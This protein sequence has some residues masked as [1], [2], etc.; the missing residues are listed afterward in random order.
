MV[1]SS[2]ELMRGVV[3][4]L[5]PDG[6]T[7]GT[8]FLVHQDGFIATCS[9]V[10]QSIKDQEGNPPRPEKVRVRFRATGT[11][12]EALVVHWSPFTL[13]DVAILKLMG[14]VPPGIEPLPLG[15]SAGVKGH[16]LE[17]FGFPE[18]EWIDGLS[19]GG[20]ILAPT[21]RCGFPLLQVRSTEITAGFSGAP[22]WDQLRRRV[23]GMITLF[24]A[25]DKFGRL[26]ESAFLVPADTLQNLCPDLRA[27]DLCPYQGL[28]AF[29]EERSEFFFG[30]REVIEKLVSHLGGGSRFLAVLGPSGSGKSSLIRAGLIPRLRQGA[31]W[32]SDRWEIQVSRPLE[33][34]F[35]ALADQG[36][37]AVSAG[38]QDV[39]FRRLTKLSSGESLLLV[40]DQFE[41]LLVAYPRDVCAAIARQLAE[42]LGSSSPLI[43]ILVMRNDF[44]SLFAEL[45]VVLVPW[46]EKN[47]VN[48][49][50]RLSRDQVREIIVE[51]AG[52]VGWELEQGL[53]EV[54]LEDVLKTGGDKASD[55]LSAPAT[56][57]PLLEFALTELWEHS[58][59]E[60]LLTHDAFQRIKK[61]GGGLSQRAAGIY[62]DLPAQQ[63]DLA[64]QIFLD[65]V[66]LGEESSL[67][68][69]KRLCLNDLCAAE[70]D[71][72]QVRALVRHLSDE[73]QRL[74]VASRDEQSGREHV[75]IIHEA[76][77]REWQD[78]KDWIQ[79][80][81]RFL[82][83]R[84]ELHKKL[85]PWIDTAP[86]EPL[87]RDPERLLL[88]RDLTEA[89]SWVVA[90]RSCLGPE[91]IAY[92]DASQ[93]QRSREEKRWQEL[94][95]EAE[96][97][98]REAEDQRRLALARQLAAQA[99]LVRGTS[100]ESLIISTLLTAESL[101]HRPTLE[102]DLAISRC[103]DRLSR[104]MASL[105]HEDKVRWVV[106]SP[107]GQLLATA[108]ED[109]TA[110][111]WNRQGQEL[112]RLNHEDAVLTVAFSPDG[113][114]LA[115]ASKD[116][117][118]RLWDRQG[119]ELM[120]LQHEDWVRSLAFSLD[121]KLLATASD[122]W[123]ARL[124]DHQGRE[125][126]RLKHN[127]GVW[128]LA[129]SPD[130]QF[131][132]TASEDKTARL[133]DLQGQEVA[134][135]VHESLVSSV[136]IS[137]DGQVLATASLD[138]T[139]CLWNPQGRELTRVNH[140]D[141][142]RS[143]AFSPDGQVLATASSDRTARLWDLQGQEL[144]R[145][146][147]ED[148]IL[149]VAFSPDGQFLATASADHSA[150]LWDRQG[151]ELA[152]LNH[153]DEINMVA[154]SSDGRL[155]ATASADH[156]TRLWERASREVAR[157]IHAG[158]VNAVTFS[159]DGE[160]LATASGD[161]TVRL[162]D[163][164]G[165]ELV[166]LNQEDAVL[167]VAFSPDGGV[168]AT[169]SEDHTARLWS[170]QGQ[171]LVC[172]KHEDSV[173]TVVFSPDGQM[174]ATAS[175]D[176]TIRF[177][178]HQGR[179]LY[180]LNYKAKVNAVAF[181]PDDEVLATG[182]ED[183]TARFWDRQ[184]WEL[185][186]I[187][188]NS[189]V[190]SVAF[191]P[192]GQILA[193]ASADHTA[194]LWD[195]QGLELARLNHEGKVNDI[196]FSPDGQFLVTASE[197]KTARLWD[198]QGRE[199][200]RLNHE[201]AVRSVAFSRDGQ[202]LATASGDKTARLWLWRPEDLIAE[203]CRW[204]P[205]NLTKEEWPQYLGDEPYRPTCPELPIP[206]ED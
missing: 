87:V 187:Y 141:R 46:L 51:P 125:L 96:N 14:D 105:N 53:V 35:R 85:R 24:T 8:G 157:V 181:S 117:T 59:S 21:Q 26:T 17:T 7:A 100:E 12:V 3:R 165:R 134:C 102:G 18:A 118:A 190:S 72:E 159:P 78:L 112:A 199:L 36:A 173:L 103:L 32:G 183:H 169:A 119:Q 191:S 149:S 205:R 88:G 206:G 186:R 160:V 153:Y 43:I 5:A 39:I 54:I 109:H 116:R 175:A 108:S 68:S 42:L 28:A 6:A 133:W 192:D 167:S 57:L 203:V 92:I 70:P 171:E 1:N 139:V 127:L 150:R 20:D 195:R 184:F 56:V 136:T 9:H 144:V 126:V 201:D 94:Y 135:M 23:I 200:A 38:L 99:E 82:A 162:W 89:V 152:R 143:L 164:Q 189:G 55:P 80:D 188:H 148:A 158:L 71:R 48:V 73:K 161:K 198:Q 65:L 47:L 98:R 93:A 45:A 66:Q 137:P 81:R 155:L 129:F 193:T 128:S 83:W 178:D 168:L 110:R 177:W 62:R 67:D 123:T 197:D 107:D 50:A 11:E 185:A 196:A 111:L 77:L 40:I 121:G 154:F 16:K 79:E 140:D 63:R 166:C 122:D 61:V 25:T 151:R 41:E 130:G 113:Q 84:Q 64:R 194:C 10:V 179:E 75:E 30:R 120:R 180:R 37:A 145:L 174:L 176:Q 31:A 33:E 74:L 106:F 114:V 95:E 97:Q 91:E 15:T 19:G 156:T 76:L 182:S 138:H 90:R 104:E 29:T 2:G 34:P 49:P 52:A 60:G 170:R 146:N 115:T 204:L 172:L 131:L 202:L 124:W 163:R 132:A 4:I 86:Q 142:V 27:K 101:R 69:R 58:R 147:H 22:V 13:A 44:Y